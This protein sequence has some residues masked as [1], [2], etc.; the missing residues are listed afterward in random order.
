M[1]YLLVSRN[2]RARGVTRPKR[3]NTGPNKASAQ[4]EENAAALRQSPSSILHRPKQELW[5]EQTTEAMES[6]PPT[7]TIQVK[8][9]GRTIPVEVPATATT[10]E[11]KRL[12]QPLTNVLPRGQKLVCKGT[13]AQPSSPTES[14]DSLR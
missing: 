8:F 7:I 11:L 14:A 13:D 5:K 9:A 12:L 6:T 1:L 10:A 2:G 3:L 4:N